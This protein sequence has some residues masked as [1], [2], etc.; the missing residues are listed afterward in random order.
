[1]KYFVAAMLLLASGASMAEPARSTTAPAP[2]TVEEAARRQ[3]IEQQKAQAEAMNLPPA[4]SA[5]DRP[6]ILDLPVSHDDSPGATKK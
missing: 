4:Q 3:Q 2:E 5:D 6:Q 1:M